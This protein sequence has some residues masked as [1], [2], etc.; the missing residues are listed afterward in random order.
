MHLDYLLI[1]GVC[2]ESAAFSIN[3]LISKNV[4]LSLSHSYSIRGS[5]HL[6]SSSIPSMQYE[7]ST[8]T[9]LNSDLNINIQNL[10]EKVD[11][12]LAGKIGSVEQ[13]KESIVK[14]I[15]EIHAK[16]LEFCSPFISSKLR[17]DSKQNSIS[18]ERI[19]SNEENPHPIA[20]RTTDVTQ[21]LLD[22]YAIH[23]IRD[24]AETQWRDKNKSSSR[25]TYQRKGNYEAHLIDLATNV[26]PELLSIVNTA[27]EDRIYPLVQDVYSDIIDLED[28]SFQIYDS[29][30][31]RYNAT[32]AKLFSNTIGAGQ[33]L[34]R[35]LGIVSVNIMLNEEFE[36]GG[37]LL[38]NQL[39]R[40]DVVDE[41]VEPLKP[42]GAGHAVSHLSSE[43]H[44]GVGTTDGV[45]DIL[46]MFLTATR[47]N[48]DSKVPSLERTARLKSM[49][50]K[51]SLEFGSNHDAILCRILHHRLATKY[52]PTDGEAY[53]YLGMSLRDYAKIE[54]NQSHAL[55]IMLLAIRCLLVAF[56]RNP[57]DGRLSNNIA[58][59]YE[60]L[61]S[62]ANKSGKS[63][64]P[65]EMD[66]RIVSFYRR[67]ML[68]HQQC[69]KIGCDVSF[70]FDCA[71]L[72]FGLYEANQDL[73]VEAINVLERFESS[74]SYATN[75]ERNEQQD[76]MRN[77]ALGLLEFCRRTLTN[78]IR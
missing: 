47:K 48:A 69:D 18:Y 43:R 31:I 71:T 41:S 8:Q 58:L 68:L 25:F 42:I 75:E 19:Y 13:E 56:E 65:I 12:F 15:D 32:E 30:V 64:D 33:P 27:L 5:S 28:L 24:A 9:K 49:T 37:T 3:G 35:D 67:A 26:N 76:R 74:V 20:I 23:A 52:T 34:H 60:N 59:S 66:S 70:D 44:A 10:I 53:Q 39:S 21:P 22:P 57:C 73:F 54:E 63:I 4:A 38:E 55:D 40:N 7:T 6:R 2:A 50:R 1:L 14:R 11:I 62:M 45:R 77:D 61:L 72:N 17:K 36:G 16:D 78:K 51:H 46:V 29:L